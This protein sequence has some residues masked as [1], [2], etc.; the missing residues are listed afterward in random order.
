M[1]VEQFRSEVGALLSLGWPVWVYRG[2]VPK[3][4]LITAADYLDV[5][6]RAH[7]VK[8]ARWN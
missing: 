1:T 6:W 2:D 5:E 7:F 8:G 4:S 3:R